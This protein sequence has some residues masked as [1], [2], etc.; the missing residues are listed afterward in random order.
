MSLTA[1]FADVSIVSTTFTKKA[2]PSATHPPR[3]RPWWKGMTPDEQ[4]AW[5]DR[6][7]PALCPPGEQ[8]LP[9]RWW[10]REKERVRRARNPSEKEIDALR[11]PC[12]CTK[13]RQTRR[14]PYPSYYVAN[15]ISYECWLEQQIVDPELRELLIP[16]RNHHRRLGAVFV[17]DKLNNWKIKKTFKES[18]RPINLSAL[19]SLC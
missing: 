11:R 6:N 13:C 7:D 3:G 1:S 12:K 15:G 14:P 10:N 2:P 8:P 19:S 4:D 18:S 17:S 5:L 9:V 16:L